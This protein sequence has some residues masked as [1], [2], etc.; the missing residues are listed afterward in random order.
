MMLIP[1]PVLGMVTSGCGLIH[2]AD[3]LS[4]ARATKLGP[5]P[6]G[7]V[8]NGIWS[9]LDHAPLRDIHDLVRILPYT[10]SGG[11]GRVAYIPMA[12][13]WV[14]YTDNWIGGA[15]TPS[16]LGLARDRLGCTTIHA[17]HHDTKEQYAVI[18]DTLADW[19]E[20]GYRAIHCYR[21]YGR[22]GF[23]TDGTPR[24][25]EDTARYTEKRKRDR[26]TPEMLEQYLCALGVPPLIPDNFFF[27]ETVIL[28]D[29]AVAI[30]NRITMASK[31]T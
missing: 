21:D 12:D 26:F 13:G 23:Q 19:G 30:P 7:I 25:F 3:V 1:S 2:G 20:P 11:P 16:V 24:P 14:C 27:S 18:L 4:I 29:L 28:E 17:A 9:R 22:W 8:F 15:D 5:H 10:N 6:D 31:P